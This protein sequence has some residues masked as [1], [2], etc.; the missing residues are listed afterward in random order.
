MLQL[1][2]YEVKDRSFLTLSSDVDEYFWMLRGQRMRR[3]RTYS[4]VGQAW[5]E[6]EKRNDSF[7]AGK[8]SGLLGHPVPSMQSTDQIDGWTNMKQKADSLGRILGGRSLLWEE[9]CSLLQGR[10]GGFTDEKELRRLLQVLLLTR[11]ARLLPGVYTPGPAVHRKCNRC[12]GGA[13]DLEVTPC[14]RC[15]RFCVLCDRCILLGKSRTCSGFFLFEPQKP[16]GTPDKKNVPFASVPLTSAQRD[17]SEASLRWLDQ[18]GDRDLLVWAVTGSGK[19]EVLLP[20]VHRVLERGEKVFWSS[21]RTDVVRELSGRLKRAFPATRLVALHKGS[22]QIWEEGDLFVGTAHQAFRLYHRFQLVIVDEADAYPLSAD[23]GLSLALKRAAAPEGMR[24]L[25]TATP[26]PSWQRRVQKGRLEAVTLPARY[27]G[28][29]LPEPHLRRVWRMWR[30]V[31]AGRPIPPLDSFL[32]RM[33]EVDGQAL[34]FIPGVRDAD[35]LQRWMERRHPRLFRRVASVSGKD[36]E[37]ASQVKAF[38]EGRLQ[39]LITT[40]ILERGVTVPRC[41]VAVLGADHPVF[42]GASLIQI[43]GRVGRSPE[44]RQGRV[45]FFASE[46]TEGQRRALRE[47]RKMNRLA[48]SGGYLKKEV[49]S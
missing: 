19:T 1:A 5:L 37:R 48:V 16:F 29:P 13:E 38:R 31:D 43:A 40:T 27:H 8:L 12:G 49:G 9:I 7:V 25:L 17:A 21:P 44:Y 39:A 34:L 20:V 15:G 41:H 11:Q 36:A 10:W 23:T 18:S 4:S 6:A 46:N 22:S 28:Y 33:E 47:I 30:K 24:V 32:I 3:F 26:P 2:V 35:R 45:F 14:A 42:D